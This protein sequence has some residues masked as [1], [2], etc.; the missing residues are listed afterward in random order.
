MFGFGHQFNLNLR[1]RSGRLLSGE[2]RGSPEWRVF[3]V[4]RRPQRYAD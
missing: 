2:L 3:A 1:A 4:N